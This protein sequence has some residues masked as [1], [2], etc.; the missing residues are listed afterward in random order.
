MEPDPARHRK[1]GDRNQN[2]VQMRQKSGQNLFAE[3]TAG[4]MSGTRRYDPVA[5]DDGV[6]GAPLDE[7]AVTGA[8]AAVTSPNVCPVASSTALFPVFAFQRLT[9]TYLATWVK[10]YSEH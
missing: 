5:S 10:L 2:W 3:W 9:A 1:A 4:C 7:F 6:S 8:R